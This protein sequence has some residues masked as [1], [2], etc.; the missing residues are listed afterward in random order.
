V[1]NRPFASRPL[2]FAAHFA[3]RHRP[4]TGQKRCA[5]FLLTRGA[6]RT[7][8]AEDPIRPPP[9]HVAVIGAVG[10][11][12]QGNLGC[13]NGDSGSEFP[14]PEPLRNTRRKCPVIVMT[15]RK[16]LC[17]R[18]GPHCSSEFRVSRVR[19]GVAQEPHADHDQGRGNH[20][21][22]LPRCPTEPFQRLSKPS[23]SENTCEQTRCPKH[24]HYE[25]G[26][27]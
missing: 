23:E 1:R 15:A 26:L 13:G 2:R 20:E 3:V 10:G 7:P 27:H 25:C 17:R 6:M 8:F 19:D 11:L 12:G 21:P 16:R 18:S 4:S 22:P 14:C 9:H 24:R 5:A